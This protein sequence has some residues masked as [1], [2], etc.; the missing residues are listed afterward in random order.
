M[1]F[2]AA[3]TLRSI[4]ARPVVAPLFELT[5]SC[6]RCCTMHVLL[7]SRPMSTTRTTTSECDCPANSH[8]FMRPALSCSRSLPWCFS[9]K[10]HQNVS[11]ASSP[12]TF[13]QTLHGQRDR[14]HI[15]SDRYALAQFVANLALASQFNCL[16]MAGLSEAKLVQMRAWTLEVSLDQLHRPAAICIPQECARLYRCSAKGGNCGER[17][18]NEGG[19]RVLRLRQQLKNKSAAG[20]LG[21]SALPQRR[22]VHLRPRGD[23]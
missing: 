12:E 15:R 14:A 17:T 2:R 13:H 11:D 3:F 21:L 16:E 6:A 18:G 20:P 4:R 10:L 5:G 1:L 19:C 8:V 22:E 23:S 9:S 7:R